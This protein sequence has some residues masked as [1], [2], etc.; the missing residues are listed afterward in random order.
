MKRAG[1]EGF[2]AVANDAMYYSAQT[3]EYLEK[4]RIKVRDT[5]APQLRFRTATGTLYRVDL[6]SDVFAWGLLLFDGK[7]KPVQADL[8]EPE[9]GVKAVFKK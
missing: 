5:S 9:A 2:Y 8:V 6:R 7:H 3:Q 1:E 4:R